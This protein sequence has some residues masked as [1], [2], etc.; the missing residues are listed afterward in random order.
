MAVVSCV[1]RTPRRVLWLLMFLSNVLVSTVTQLRTRLLN[2]YIE[3]LDVLLE[4]VTLPLQS[5]DPS[6]EQDAPPLSLD[7]CTHC[8]VSVSA[9]LRGL[10]PLLG[11]RPPHP[12]L[13]LAAQL[14]RTGG[15]ALVPP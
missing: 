11:A 2:D 7:C 6:G 15:A 3:A 10:G 4:D 14:G 1:V 12:G 9:D 13:C 5:A 8:T